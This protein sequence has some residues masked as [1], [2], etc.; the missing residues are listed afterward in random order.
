MFVH[1]NNK[2]T[3]FILQIISQFYMYILPFFNFCTK[4]MLNILLNIF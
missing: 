2:S 4:Y 1:F 3:I